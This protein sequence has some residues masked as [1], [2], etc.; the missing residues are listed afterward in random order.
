MDYVSLNKKR[1]LPKNVNWLYFGDKNI[2]FNR[3]SETSTM[4]RT[5]SKKGKTYLTCEITFQKNDYIDKLKFKDLSKRVIEDLLKLKI[6]KN[7]NEVDLTSENKENFVYP[8]Q[9][10]N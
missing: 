4:T 3:V 5:V 6:I 8:I 7:K 1:A 9:F 10:V 2:I